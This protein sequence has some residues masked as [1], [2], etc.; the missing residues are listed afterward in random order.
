MFILTRKKTKEINTKRLKTLLKETVFKFDN[1]PEK[2]SSF[3]KSI[4]IQQNIKK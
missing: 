4:T 1:N 3:I 2:F